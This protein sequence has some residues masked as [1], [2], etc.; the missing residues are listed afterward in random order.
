MRPLISAQLVNGAF[1]DPVL[2]LDFRDARRA[3]LFDVGDVGALPPARILRLTDLF[4]SHAHLDH[5][6]G[7]ERLLRVGLGRHPGLRLYGPPGFLD[8]VAHKLAAYSWNKVRNYPGDYALTAHEIAPGGGVRRARFGSASAFARE[9]L[10]ETRCEDGVLLQEPKFRV[11]AAFLDHDIP[12]LGFA[13]EEQPR[14][15]VR[16]DALAALGLAAGPWLGALRRALAEERPDDTP[17]RVRWQ[18]R[19]GAHERQVALGVLKSRALQIVPGQKVAYVTDVRGTPDNEARIAQLAADADL[20]YIEAVFLGADAAH[21]ERKHHLT[22]AQAGRIARAA[23]AR[24]VVPFHFSPRY[25]GREDELRAELERARGPLLLPME[26][27][28]KDTLPQV[29]APDPELKN[30]PIIDESEHDEHAGSPDLEIEEGVCYFNDEAFAIGDFV[31]SG[32]EVLQCAERGVWLR[33]GE[34]RPD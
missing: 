3:L 23:R 12:C 4:V 10:P 11:R 1:G 27:A 13:F 24:N 33:K 28:V 32:S 29:G 15:H 14:V 16:K 17:I 20:L 25:R 21:A 34:K 26:T 31:R 2:Y 7:F 9:P 30:S 22:A 5:F 18:D 6:A 19:A 8:R